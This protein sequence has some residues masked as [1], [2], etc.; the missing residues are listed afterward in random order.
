MDT[1]SNQSLKNSS[2][3]TYSLVQYL[4]WL[5]IFPLA[6]IYLTK[7]SFFVYYYH[8]S[9]GGFRLA[10][11]LRLL[12]VVIQEPAKLR[13]IRKFDLP[14]CQLWNTRHLVFSTCSAQ[15]KN[16]ANT[17]KTCLPFSNSSE[18]NFYSINVRKTWEAWL[19]PLLLLRRT[20]KYLANEKDLPLAQFVLV[21]PFASLVQFLKLDHNS[22][23]EISVISQPFENKSAFYSLGA[24]WFS[25]WRLVKK[26]MH[27]FFKPPMFSTSP[28]KQHRMLELK[29]FGTFLP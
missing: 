4:T 27:L 29:H 11:L 8:A 1:F 13:D 16:I 21:S 24:S 26:L 6:K 25:L 22:A 20:G 12:G 2:L 5:S 15:L 14:C 3:P 7:G 28:K 18:I 19:E 23:D 10:S 17:A 9:T